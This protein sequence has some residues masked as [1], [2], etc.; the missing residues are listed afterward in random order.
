MTVLVYDIWALQTINQFW[1]T[2]ETVRAHP[3]CVVYAVGVHAAS[4]DRPVEDHTR[5]VL[6]VGICSLPDLSRDN[7]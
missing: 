4:L 1:E 3:K 6:S 5:A 2:K 7:S